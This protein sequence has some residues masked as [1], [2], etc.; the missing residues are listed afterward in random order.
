MDSKPSAKSGES[1]SAAIS[2]PARKPVAGKL[3]QL[4]PA[5]VRLTRT[6]DYRRV[7]DNGTRRQFGWMA[8]FLLR[9][10]KQPSRIGITVPRA[11][12][13]AVQR[14]RMKRRLRHAIAAT[15]ADLHAGWDIVLHPRPAGLKLDYEELQATLR[16]IF[17]YCDKRAAE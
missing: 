17:L 2:Q 12:G 10:G 8:A 4:S 9:T 1:L 13:N 14:N 5:E 3:S 7:Y 6:A 11:F 16:R 15:L